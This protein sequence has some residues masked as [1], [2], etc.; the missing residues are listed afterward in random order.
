MERMHVWGSR[1][2]LP[3]IGIKKVD[4]KMHWCCISLLVKVERDFLAK[5]FCGIIALINSLGPNLGPPTYFYCLKLPLE[6]LWLLKYQFFL[7]KK[8]PP[9]FQDWLTSCFQICMQAVSCIRE[10]NV[11]GSENRIEIACDTPM[12][13]YSSMV[14]L[15][16]YSVLRYTHP[17]TTYGK[18]LHT[19]NCYAVTL[20][21]GEPILYTI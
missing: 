2:R 4:Y 16:T 1:K 5:Q 14:Q 19:S 15:C 9:D 7:Y 12:F 21:P 3:V 17:R 18:N 8:A 13:A 10:A 20:K 6:K 11:R